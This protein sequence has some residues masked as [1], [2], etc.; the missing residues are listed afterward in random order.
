MQ[1]SRDL[2]TIDGLQKRS[3]VYVVPPCTVD[4]GDFYI[5]D[6]IIVNHQFKQQAIESIRI[7]RNIPIQPKTKLYNQKG[8]Q[9]SDFQLRA[10]VDPKPVEV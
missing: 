8:F 5:M 4:Q 6:L 3:C 10:F 7:T 9:F 2:W 1:F